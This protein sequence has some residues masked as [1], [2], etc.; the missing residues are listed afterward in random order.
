MGKNSQN[1]LRDR[2]MKDHHTEEDKVGVIL[3]LITTHLF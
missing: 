2:R 1:G 3:Y